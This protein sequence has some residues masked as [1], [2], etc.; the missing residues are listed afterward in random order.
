MGVTV[1][2]PT[3]VEPSRMVTTL[4]VSVVPTNAGVVFVVRLSVLEL[5]LSLAAIKSGVEGATGAFLS[6]S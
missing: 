5:P 3:T 6:M 1:T 2:V 4:F